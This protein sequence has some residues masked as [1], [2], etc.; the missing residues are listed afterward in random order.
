LRR[1]RRTIGIQI[2]KGSMLRA[3]E[4]Q[5]IH[6]HA[7]RAVEFAATGVIAGT[8]QFEQ[9][10]SQMAEGIAANDQSA[11]GGFANRAIQRERYFGRGFAA[12]GEMPSGF[13]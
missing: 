8:L 4:R 9:S 10:G 5:R 2:E 12:V 13:G 11:T 3:A 7:P 6:T 1:D